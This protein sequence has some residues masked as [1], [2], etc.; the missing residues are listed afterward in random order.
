MR[1]LYGRFGTC[2]DTV[3]GAC[4]GALDVRRIC[5]I[6]GCEGFVRMFVLL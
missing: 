1:S 4:E 2:E 3:E 5:G 6:R